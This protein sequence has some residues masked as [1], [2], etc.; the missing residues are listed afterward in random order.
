[1]RQQFQNKKKIN[2][3]VKRKIRRKLLHRISGYSA[4]K[5]K[6]LLKLGWNILKHYSWNPLVLDNYTI[7][8]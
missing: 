1:M 7:G 5:I 3:K 4:C 8:L 2:L 6:L